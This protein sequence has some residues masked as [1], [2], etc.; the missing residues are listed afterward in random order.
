MKTRNP[1]SRR[2][3]RAFTLVEMLVVMG[4]IVVL[5]SMIFPAAAM[6]KKKATLAKA[7]SEMK[8]VALAIQAYKENLGHY[9]PDHIV[10]VGGR[11]EAHLTNSLYFELCGTVQKGND[12]ETLDGA[13]RIPVADVPGVFGQGGFMNCSKGGADDN[14]QAAKA[15][16]KKLSPKHYANIWEPTT[17]G[18]RVLTCSV[19]W[20]VAS[21]TILNIPL[22][23]PWRYDCSSTNRNNHDAFDLWVDIIVGGKTNRISNWSDTPTIVP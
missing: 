16:L 3:L 15:I 4:V 12:F 11:Q 13:A 2:H 22:A 23:N 9:P 17:P 14:A 18:V 8:L 5:A 6:Y 7:R 20:P 21:G 10:V 1:I 19:D